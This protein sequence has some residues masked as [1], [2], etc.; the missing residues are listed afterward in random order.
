M[1]HIARTGAKIQEGFV[2]GSKYVSLFIWC[3]RNGAAKELV[4]LIAGGLL[5]M[6]DQKSQLAIKARLQILSV[7]SSRSSFPGILSYARIV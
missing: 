3:S 4:R 2:F 1:Y 7:I 5:H 6:F